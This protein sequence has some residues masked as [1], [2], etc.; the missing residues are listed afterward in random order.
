M[1][2]KAEV[3]L[4]NLYQF[5]EAFNGIASCKIFCPSFM[6]HHFKINSILLMLFFH[7]L[8]LVLALVKQFTLASSIETLL[9]SRKP[10]TRMVHHFPIQL[11]VNGG[12]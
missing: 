9:S 10:A 8:K 12:I 1:N 6:F 7:E 5:D 3:K 11:F 4:C 2:Y